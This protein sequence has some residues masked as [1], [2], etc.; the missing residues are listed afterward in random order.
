MFK[1]TKDTL[2]VFNSFRFKNL[3]S[4]NGRDG[5]AY[6]CE[7][8]Y[9][10]EKIADV[11]DRGDG[12]MLYIDYATGGRELLNSLNVP[13]Y[14]DKDED[15][16]FDVDNE[17]IIADLCEV[18]IWVK[19]SLRKQ[20]NTIVFIKGDELH[21]IKLKATIAQYA[22]AGKM[23]LLTDKVKDLESKGFVVLN[24]NIG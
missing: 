3:K 20:S 23:N 11:E 15:L 18:A 19:S 17:Y 12:G 13:Q 7:L 4:L 8:F 5:V 14:F 10:N 21:E 9:K 22:A 2:P 24:T 1:L 6:T 16:E